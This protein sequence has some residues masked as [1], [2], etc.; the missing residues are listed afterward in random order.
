MLV[1]LEGWTFCRYPAE[2]AE[3]V[4]SVRGW[5]GMGVGFGDERWK[6]QA[7]VSLVLFPNREMS[8]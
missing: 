6:M 2:M 8:R 3:F 7:M 4:T 1:S 5:F